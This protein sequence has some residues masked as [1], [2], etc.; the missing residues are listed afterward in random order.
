MIFTADSKYGSDRQSRRIGRRPAI[1]HGVALVTIESW[2]PASQ[3]HTRS[4][5]V[6]E[7][8]LAGPLAES[9]R[10]DP[11]YRCNAASRRPLRELGAH[12]VDRRAFRPRDAGGGLR[13]SRRQ[14]HCAGTFVRGTGR[15]D[16]T[17]ACCG[18]VRRPRAKRARSNRPCASRLRSG[19]RQPPLRDLRLVLSLRPGTG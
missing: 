2:D 8:Q 7:D 9:P 11:Q 12:A 17:R 4:R 13:R 15:G 3:A 14:R 18:L 19:L 6:A 1:R 5:A 10:A 16:T